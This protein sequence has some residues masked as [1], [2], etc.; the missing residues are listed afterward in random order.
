LQIKKTKR[1]EGQVGDPRY[2]DGV[3]KCI[4]RRCAILG[5]DAP[6]KIAGPTGGDF[7]VKVVKGVSFDDL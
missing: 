5:I 6:K 2:L 7:I 1:R 3:L 4:D